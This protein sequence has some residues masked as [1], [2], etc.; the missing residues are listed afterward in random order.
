LHSPQIASLEVLRLGHVRRAKLYYLRD[1][2][3]KAA[4]V[5]EKR[6]TVKTSKAAPKS[7]PETS[8]DS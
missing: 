1:R 4:R 3:G 6:R 2:K 8:P 7:A 5:R